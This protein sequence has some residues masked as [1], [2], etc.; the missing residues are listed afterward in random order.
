[1]AGEKSVDAEDAEVKQERAQS[2]T[3]EMYIQS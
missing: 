2:K 3:V 1:M